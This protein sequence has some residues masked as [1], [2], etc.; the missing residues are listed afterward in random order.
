MFRAPNGCPGIPWGAET[1]SSCRGALVFVDEAR[2]VHKLSRVYRTVRF[3]GRSNKCTPRVPGTGAH[4]EFTRGGLH[5]PPALNPETLLVLYLG[6]E[7]AVA[8]TCERVGAEP[9]EPANP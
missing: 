5:E 9:V 1:R 4:L 2:G 8:Q 7:E 6:S 3:A